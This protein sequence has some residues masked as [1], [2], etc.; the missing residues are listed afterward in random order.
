MLKRV[1]S[2]AAVLLGVTTCI[3]VAPSAEA[4]APPP[5][6]DAGWLCAYYDASYGG[7]SPQHVSG[8]NDDLTG[9]DLFYNIQG[10]S[11]YNNGTQCNVTVYTGKNRGG[12]AYPLNRG[13]GWKSIGSNL[14]HI[15]SNHWC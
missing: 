10:G 3:A 7:G 13:T 1:L 11:L 9:F 14:P 5:Y 6:C 12:S 2:A 15:E 8:N 4:A